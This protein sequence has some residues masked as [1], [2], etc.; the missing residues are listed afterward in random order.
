MQ[1]LRYSFQ[2]PW[3]LYSYNQL[4]Q[5]QTK[6]KRRFEQ[7]PKAILHHGMFNSIDIFVDFLYFGEIRL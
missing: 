3:Q 6:L 2:V 4:L 7:I 5:Y 1:I